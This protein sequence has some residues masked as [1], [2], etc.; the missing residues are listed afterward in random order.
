MVAV[1]VCTDQ[2]LVAVARENGSIELWNSA[3]WY[4]ALVRLDFHLRDSQRATGLDCPPHMQ[5]IPGKE[6]ASFTSLCWAYD[7]VYDQWRLFSCGLDGY[8]VEWD[9]RRRQPLATSSTMGG[10]AWHM[11]ARPVHQPSTSADDGPEDPLI[12]LATDDGAVRIL[13]AEPGQP[14]LQYRS[15]AGRADARALCVAWRPDGAVLYAG[16]S[17]GC[18]R[19]MDVQSGAAPTQPRPPTTLSHHPIPQE[20]CTGPAKLMAVH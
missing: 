8:V 20:V 11:A 5:V 19:A 4:C 15:T 18:I 2:S 16:F 14:G 3:A 13:A 17:D 1:A 9:L 10:A 7:N 12:A 6:E